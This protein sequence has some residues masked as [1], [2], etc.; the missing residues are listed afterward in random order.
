VVST[1]CW[2]AGY[3]SVGDG[4]NSDGYG[5]YRMNLLSIFDPSGWS[6]ILNDIPES[7]GDY[8]GFNF[9]GL[10]IIFLITCA[11]PAIF[12]DRGRIGTS[13]AIGK[14]PMLSL[15]L[16][17][18]TAYAASNKIGIGLLGFE[19]PLPDLALKIANTF[20]ASGRIFW[21]VF[22]TILFVTTLII[23]RGYKKHTAVFL[24]GLALF[25]QVIDTHSGWKGVHMRL[26]IEPQSEWSIPLSDPFWGK[27][28][29]RYTKVRWIPPSNHSPKWLTLAAFAGTHGLAT[30]AMNLARIG[31]L[32]ME[33]ARSKALEA[34]QTG[35]YEDDS[36]Y[37]MDDSVIRQAAFT[38]NVDTDVLTRVD[39]FTILA[40]GWK[41]CTECPS[42]KKEVKLID[43]LPTL[44]TGQR[45]LLNQSGSG[46][47]YLAGGWSHPEHWGIWSDGPKA[48]IVLPF[49]EKHATSI[50]IEANPLLS[51]SHPQQH[52]EVFINGV[53][54]R[55]ITLDTSYKGMFE[56]KIPE[57]IL[58]AD[59][60]NN[61]LEL[62]FHFPDAARPKDIGINDDVRELALGFIAITTQ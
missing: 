46:L 25:I 7:A 35:R 56:V 26:T 47:A 22:Y 40:P 48:T 20:R 33:N 4:V 52:I 42:F 39:G 23:I 41:K 38:I 17:V 9:L 37:F 2:Q 45:M 18:L 27:A 1:A 44:Q 10:G 60:K 53:P 6:Y 5:F 54:V 29:S 51:P 31:T 58:E 3:F 14:Y 34:L 36:L 62:E 21:P 8:E 19:Y 16:V 15:L 12:E 30:D 11:L 13:R 57:S 24:L 55:E 28:A 61:T 43:L 32:A 49:S 50:L 59:W